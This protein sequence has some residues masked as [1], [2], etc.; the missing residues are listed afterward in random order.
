VGGKNRQEIAFL[1]TLSQTGHEAHN[2]VMIF[3]SLEKMMRDV[4]LQSTDLL[5]GEV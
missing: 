3:L 2:V 1:P 4:E 5:H